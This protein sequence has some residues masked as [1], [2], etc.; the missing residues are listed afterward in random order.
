MFVYLQLLNP[1]KVTQT[2]PTPF[3]INVLSSV[4]IEILS[5]GL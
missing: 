5:A 1:S 2:P 3:G 4:C